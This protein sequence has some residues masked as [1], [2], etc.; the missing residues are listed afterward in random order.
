MSNAATQERHIPPKR[1]R[2]LDM[3]M[4]LGGLKE[5]AAIP[6]SRVNEEIRLLKEELSPLTAEIVAYPEKYFQEFLTA[7]ERAGIIDQIT[8]P[9]I[10]SE[11]INNLEAALKTGESGSLST[12][13]G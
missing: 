1:Q 11:A 12:L 7:V 6:L 10:L 3:I 8:D 5:E 9:S 13:L 2:M 4:V